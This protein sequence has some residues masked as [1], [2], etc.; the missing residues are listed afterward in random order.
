[1]P[2]MPKMREAAKLILARHVQHSQDV[3]VK[4]VGWIVV[5]MV[6]AA[7]LGIWTDLSSVWNQHTR[8]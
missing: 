8:F 4:K 2:W 3:A 6:R 7:V 1:M 5:R